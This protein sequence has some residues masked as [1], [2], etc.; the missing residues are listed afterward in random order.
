[1]G[2]RR[3]REGGTQGVSIRGR[4]MRGNGEKGKRRDSEKGA[5]RGKGMAVEG[6]RQGEEMQVC[7]SRMQNGW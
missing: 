2:R 7:G 5:M 4:G 3:G 6:G 1:M